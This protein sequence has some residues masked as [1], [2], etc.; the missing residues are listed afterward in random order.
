[1]MEVTVQAKLLS[2]NQ[3]IARVNLCSDKN[4]GS[5]KLHLQTCE[6]SDNLQA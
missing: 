1:M 6:H 3:D 4:N 5:A 2:Q